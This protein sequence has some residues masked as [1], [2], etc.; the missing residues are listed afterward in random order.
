MTPL[1]DNIRLKYYVS[2]ILKC[3]SRHDRHRQTLKTP[4]TTHFTG[5]FDGHTLVAFGRNSYKTHP[6]QAKYSD[7]PH[8]IFLHSEVAA[9]VTFLNRV[10]YDAS[11]CTIVVIRHSPI[12]GLMPSK[13]CLGCMRLITEVGF[14]KVLHS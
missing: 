3:K 14:G 7:R 1:T 6:L 13:P 5:I 12:H 4:R 2:E 9:I 10:V 8:R 11:R